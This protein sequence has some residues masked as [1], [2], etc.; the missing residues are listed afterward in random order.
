MS[1]EN[2][3]RNE[4]PENSLVPLIFDK[5]SLTK[6]EYGEEMK[7]IILCFR[8]YSDSTFSYKK[9][10]K[11]YIYNYSSQDMNRNQKVIQELFKIEEA[12][13]YI[14]RFGSDDI[15]SYYE[16]VETELRKN[17]KFD[18][19][20]SILI[21]QYRFMMNIKKEFAIS[22]YTK[23]FFYKDIIETLGS[24][25]RL[26]DIMMLSKEILHEIRTFS[27]FN[28][29]IS[30][31]YKC[32]TCSFYTFGMKDVALVLLDDGI[33]QLMNIKFEDVFLEIAASFYN[34]EILTPTELIDHLKSE[35]IKKI[36]EL[37]D[38]S[39]SMLQFNFD[40][41][42]ILDI[43]FKFKDFCKLCLKNPMEIEKLSYV[44]QA[45][46]F[47]KFAII[48]L[49]EKNYVKA[50]EFAEKS[51]KIL[52]KTGTYITQTLVSIKIIL[53]STSILKDEKNYERYKILFEKFEKMKE[54]SAI[55]ILV[56][57]CQKLFPDKL[58]GGCGVIKYCSRECQILDWEKHK[59]Y[60]NNELK[61]I[62]QK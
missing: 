22:S 19:A 13:E 53:A 60:C 5:E 34:L 7:R 33:K 10:E 45:I 25:N 39:N 44:T 28:P 48:N 15:Y 40:P 59:I 21:D 37:E 2:E 56:C 27:S 35:N 31:L 23:M 6:K 14:C 16:D 11:I 42:D 30:F 58:C 32:I 18:Q 8:N 3:N 41:I 4:I 54:T 62:F 43:L 50:F 51:F 20:L 9:N 47:E 57:K 1:R 17:L 52:I 61:I 24:L 49:S 36:Q 55:G 46:L 12:K 26:E 38:L 29:H